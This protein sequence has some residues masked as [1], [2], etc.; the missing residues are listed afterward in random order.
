MHWTDIPIH[1]IDFEGTKASGILEYGV[2]T[3][4]G[5]EI[6][7]TKTRLCRAKGAITAL[8]TRQHG[9]REKD[10]QGAL[11]FSDEWEL[12]SNLHKTGPLGAHNATT[13]NMLI[14]DTWPYGKEAP[15]FLEAEKTRNTWGP[16]VDTCQLYKALY[17]QLDN[18]KLMELVKVFQLGEKLDELA[19]EH[20]PPNRSKH[21]CALYDA[22][23]SALLIQYVGELPKFEGMTIEWLLINS[24]PGSKR[25]DLEQRLF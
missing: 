21:H 10:T 4:E 25:R 23:A 18:H 11:P 24:A 13:E 22:L 15:D 3:L 14:K 9:I 1:V 6:K 17:P 8:D 12:F 19:E 7:E 2:V 20:C 5:G 16:W